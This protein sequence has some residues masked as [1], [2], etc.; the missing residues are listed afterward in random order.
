MPVGRE[1][2]TEAANVPSGSGIDRA[3][4]NVAVTSGSAGR[5]HGVG[6]AAP[7][8]ESEGSAEGQ[9]RYMRGT[10]LERGQEGREV[11]G[12]VGQAERWCSLVEQLRRRS[13]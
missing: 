8:V 10:E 9:I 12:E 1:A 3:A 4:N 6:M 5:A 2:A 11:V 13:P 7:Q